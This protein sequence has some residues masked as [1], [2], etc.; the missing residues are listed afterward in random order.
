LKFNQRAKIQKEMS[1]IPP[2]GAQIADI[3][4]TPKYQNQKLRLSPK[5]GQRLSATI[6]AFDFAVTW[7]AKEYQNFRR[8]SDSRECADQLHL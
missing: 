7:P 1:A 4:P 3:P 8:Y 5:R 2:A 6:A